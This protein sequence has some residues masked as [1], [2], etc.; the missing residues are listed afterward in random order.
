MQQA[1]AA[2][3]QRKSEGHNLGLDRGAAGLETTTKKAGAASAAQLT[4]LLKSVL[5]GK[6]S[7]TTKASG[8]CT[9]GCNGET[10]SLD[11]RFCCFYNECEIA[12]FKDYC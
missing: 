9:A 1:T 7:V 8:T 6:D 12:Q 2:P 3:A 10:G 4:E 5:E 11:D